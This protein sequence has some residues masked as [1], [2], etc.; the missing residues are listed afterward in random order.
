[1]NLTSLQVCERGNRNRICNA[2]NDLALTYYTL[3]GKAPNRLLCHH[4]VKSRLWRE[5]AMSY[6]QEG[7]DVV[8]FVATAVGEL[9]VVAR[10][11]LQ[12]GSMYVEKVE[13]EGDWIPGEVADNRCGWY[14]VTTED[15]DGGRRVFE[16]WYNA[17]APNRWYH[18]ESAARGSEVEC[19]VVAHM[20]LPKPYGGLG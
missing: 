19:K 20:P 13:R 9:A 10:D 1:M 15:S 5:E 7:S 16:A 11:D 17:F 8:M 12:P 4:V 14:L 6:K 2:I 3:T 18:R